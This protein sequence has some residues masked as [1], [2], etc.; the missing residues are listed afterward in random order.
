MPS[1]AATP[2]PRGHRSGRAAG[3]RHRR[4]ALF[5][6]VQ[7]PPPRIPSWC[8][9][10]HAPQGPGR[11]PGRLQCRRVRARSGSTVSPRPA[12]A[13]SKPMP[14]PVTAAFSTAML[15]G[16]CRCSCARIEPEHAQGGFSHRS[17]RRMTIVLATCSSVACTRRRGSATRPSCR[18]SV[19][20][21][22][23]RPLQ[24]YAREHL[25]LLAR[26]G[27][28][29]HAIDLQP[30]IVDIMRTATAWPSRPTVRLQ[31]VRSGASATSASHSSSSF[32]Q[33]K[34]GA[35][36]RLQT[37]RAM[38]ETSEG[39]R[40]AQELCEQ[41]RSDYECRPETRARM[42]SV[43]DAAID[44]RSASCALRRSSAIRSGSTSRAVTRQS[45]AASARLT[46]PVPQPRSNSS[47]GLPERRAP[48]PR[49]RAR[50]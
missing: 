28:A 36:V 23:G 27:C 6:R 10:C 38:E 17:G 4:R 43:P 7:R 42:N 24:R 35:A 21:R 45:G 47:Q 8:R 12:R 3:I 30:P 22:V 9:P 2:T 16:P 15:P 14:P 20:S 19:S 26:I 49:A 40:L 37:L 13:S 34:R 33:R 29:P 41:H 46:R 50:A 5:R 32:E 18:A 39:V 11:G 48:W 25:G 31:C 1:P 44:W